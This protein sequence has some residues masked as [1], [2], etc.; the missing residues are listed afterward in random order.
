MYN[1]SSSQQQEK[2]PGK[3]C[4]DADSLTKKTIKNA[5]NAYCANL[6][7][8]LG[9]LQQ[10]EETYKGKRTEYEHK[11][12]RVVSTERNYRIFRNAELT[13]GIQ[14]TRASANIETNVTSY[15]A[16]DTKLSAALT[17]LLAT[18]KTTKAKFSDLRDA[19]CK[20]DACCKD[21]CNRTQWAIITGEKFEDCGEEKQKP[22]HEHQ[23]GKRPHDCDDVITIIHDLIH[24][25]A[26]FSKEI[27]I[28]LN[29]SAD[30][31]G[32]QTFSNVS[33]LSQ[34]FLPIIK[35][36]AKSFDE[37]LVDGM[38]R[39]GTDLA[40]AQANLTQVIKDLADSE[41][42]KFNARLDVDAY[43][44]VK[45]FLCHHKCE[46]VCEGEGRLDKCK[47]DICAICHEVTKIY[48][49][50]AEEKQPTPPAQ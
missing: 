16:F 18:V 27:D 2:K 9:V 22:E 43:K 1:P 15:V 26:S 21:S 40:T 11:K 4:N 6:K 41:F 36:N 5:K 35:A 29:S 8:K 25:P 3:K 45:D 48:S 23:Q 33:S 39:G 34:Q 7:L 30:V 50:E 32:I 46:C 31:I 17:D 49:I 20:L 37:W 12:C 19:G 28:V 24:E 44:G 42:A 13:V 38:T 47:C 14:L 10:C